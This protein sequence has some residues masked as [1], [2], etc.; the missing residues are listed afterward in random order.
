[1]NPKQLSAL[2]RLSPTTVSRALNGYP[3]VRDETRARVIA[4]A[5]ATGYRPNGRARTL[6]TGR[7]MAV[8][9]VI[10]PTGGTGMVNPILSDFIAGA[11]EIYAA[12]GYDMLLSVARPGAE[13][14]S[15]RSLA[16]AGSV[17]GFIVH[18][19]A[20][21]DPRLPVLDEIGLPCV[22]HGRSGNAPVHHSW[23]DIANR[24]A[25]RRATD[26]LV[27]LGHRR[28]AL[29]NGQ[30]TL[31]FAQRRRQGYLD[32]LAGRGL[33]ADAGL[34][35]AD[36]MSEH[37]GWSTARALLTGQAP[38]TAFLV[39]SIIS[40]IGVQRAAVERGLQLGRDVSLITHDDCLSYLFAESEEPVFTATR[41]SIRAA[42]RRCAEMIVARIRAPDLPPIQELWDVTLTIGR[43]SGPVAG[44]GPDPAAPVPVAGSDPRAGPRPQREPE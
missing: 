38:P 35:R 32:A 4:A 5:E 17:D 10:A 29:I 15:Y 1:M 13:T 30:E 19:P 8:G 41:S 28:I 24:R 26:L 39:S 12:H 11:A 44:P 43:T 7:A 40:A 20:R 3:E 31:D 16:A 6:A 2:L 21:D 22:V 27:D 9:H 34:M 25:F 23:L 18:G 37:F 14:D 36:E 42:G 33:Q